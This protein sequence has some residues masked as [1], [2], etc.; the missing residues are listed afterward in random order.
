MKSLAIYYNLAQKQKEHTWI[1]FY[2]A[3]GEAWQST[4]KSKKWSKQARPS[5]CHVPEWF[6]IIQNKYFE[7]LLNPIQGRI[8]CY[9][10]RFSIPTMHKNYLGELLKN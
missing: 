10:Q 9:R 4:E 8:P 5:S 6:L 2:Q 3:V 7:H 1:G